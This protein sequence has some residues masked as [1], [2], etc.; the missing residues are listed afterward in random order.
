ME[1]RSDTMN[2]EE[3]E[4]FYDKTSELLKTINS[5]LMESMRWYDTDYK[6]TGKDV[7]NVKEFFDEIAREDKPC[8]GEYLGTGIDY[9]EMIN[10]CCLT[11]NEVLYINMETSSYHCNEVLYLLKEKFEWDINVE[12]FTAIEFATD[13]FLARNFKYQASSIN[14]TDGCK[15]YVNWDNANSY[16]YDWADDF[17]RNHFVTADD[18]KRVCHKYN[19]EHNYYEDDLEVSINKLKEKYNI[20]IFE[21]EFVPTDVFFLLNVTEANKKIYEKEYTFQWDSRS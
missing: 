11:I 19:T 5:E 1:K 18:I 2:K 12:Y 6:I 16:W 13:S 17:N 20:L 7:Y 9:N 14:I 21:I 15:Y 10:G 3:F 8:L 4:E